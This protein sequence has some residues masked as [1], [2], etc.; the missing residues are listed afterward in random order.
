MEF[1][2]DSIDGI[3]LDPDA[4]GAALFAAQEADRA[5]YEPGDI[6]EHACKAYALGV[7]SKA[8]AMTIPGPPAPAPHPTE[9]WLDNYA[10]W[11]E[12]YGRHWTEVVI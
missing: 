7:V 10:D 1:A 4:L 8:Q 3:Q 2:H 9:G 6:I 5:G 11:H 12:R